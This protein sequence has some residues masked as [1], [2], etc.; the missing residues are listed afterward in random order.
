MV[1]S[2]LKA[3]LKDAYLAYGRKPFQESSVGVDHR[4]R[5]IFV[6]NPKTAGTSIRSALD[7]P[8]EVPS[9][10]TPTHLVHHRTWE[11]YFSFVVVRNPFDRLVSSYVYH[12]DSDY[13]GYYL[14]KYPHL[15]GMSF[16]EYFR[17][18]QAEAFAIRPQ[19]DY[20]R[21]RFSEEK[22]DFVCRF[23]ELER[24]F[25][26][27]CDRLGIQ[28]QLPHLNRS[29]HASYRSYYRN[30]GFKQQVQA[31]YRADLKQFKYHF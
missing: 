31:F 27:L 20:C 11:E 12:T 14:T 6:H 25:G 28:A 26:R 5:L 17:A 18:M 2:G 22:V 29:H 4:R 3:T 15:H 19:V 1:P 9:H 21:H 7:I 10:R 8:G 13:R 30:D 23:E 24:D 16:E